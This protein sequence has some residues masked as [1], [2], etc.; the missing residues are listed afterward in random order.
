MQT[1]DGARALP[2]ATSIDTT[3]LSL[4]PGPQRFPE[5]EGVELCGQFHADL[6]AILSAWVQTGRALLLP[7]ITLKKTR[8]ALEASIVFLTKKA[9]DDGSAGE[10]IVLN[11]GLSVDACSTPT[12][13]YGLAAGDCSEER[14]ISAKGMGDIFSLFMEADRR[15]QE[16][17]VSTRQSAYLQQAV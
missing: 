7:A 4:I 13:D 12:S 9:G 15:Q 2:A 14:S 5:F 11:Y 8:N 17:L 6:T 1:H 16:C 10:S 3:V